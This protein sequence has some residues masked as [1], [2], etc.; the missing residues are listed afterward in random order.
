MDPYGKMRALLFVLLFILVDGRVAAQEDVAADVIAVAG[1]G[2]QRKSD[3]TS[4]LPVS[5]GGTFFLSSETGVVPMGEG[6]V[7][8]SGGTAVLSLADHG[9]VAHLA[10]NTE[11]VVDR[12]PVVDYCVPA[13]LLLAKGRIQ[14]A[15][16]SNSSTWLVVDTGA[17]G[18]LLSK[19]ATFDVGVD[20][21]AALF[22]ISAGEGLYF[23][24][25][26][27]QVALV[28]DSGRPIRKDGVAIGM[29]QQLRSSQPGEVVP[30]D[31]PEDAGKAGK[32][33]FSQTLFAFGRIAGE[34][35]I[36]NAEKGD[37]TPVRGPGRG[38]P[39][40]T[41]GGDISPEFK[42]DQPRS[43]VVAPATS[44]AAAPVR[45]VSF[46][47][48]QQ[49]QASVRPSEVIIGQRLARTRIIGPGIRANFQARPIIQLP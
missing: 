12:L 21:G 25:P 30:A 40:F 26:L 46:S 43:S 32:E 28:D 33:S 15:T 16:R 11:V 23:A 49:L 1:E 9:V 4:F 8:L 31:R 17:S 29:G 6:V 37:F 2:A 35:W 45:A 18:Y 7:T 20:N 10:N 3:G 34:R 5:A 42:F 14:V 27:P 36:V 44:A 22:R 47:Q 24:S 38:Q 48:A 13:K 19:A 41:A 39:E